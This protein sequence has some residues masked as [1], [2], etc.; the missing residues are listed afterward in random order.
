MQ[1]ME[2]LYGALA[3]QMISAAAELGIA[4]LLAG[5]PKAVAELAS[6]SG[7]DPEGL[8]RLLRGLAALG[9]FTETAPRTF[10]STP[11]GD[12]LRTDAEGSMRF[13]AQD[14]GGRTRL[15]AYSELAHSVR[16]GK[17]A[18]DKAHGTSMWSYLQSHPTELALF[19]KA[20]GNLASAAHSAAFQSYD[21]SGVRRL[22]DVGGGEGYLI[23]ALL[24]YY[25]DMTGV[26]FDEPHVVQGA[27]AV[28]AAAGLSDRT[29][30]AGGDAF[31][32]VPADGDVYVLSSILFSYLDDEVITLLSNIRKVM[33]PAGKILIL[34]PILP[35][36]NAY[37]PGKLLDV[38]QLALHRGGVRSEAEFTALF[39]AAGLRLGEIRRMWPAAPTDVV[40]AVAAEGAQ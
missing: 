33:N 26:L 17:P 34:E 5:G 20:M 35:E 30:I 37:H 11:L 22:V 10:A 36:G 13:L 27:S 21:L 16:T 12:T 6:A 29:E 9:V 18:F 38:T 4:D 7:A 15:L 31:A 8:Y 32:A 14:V 39:A 24:P 1:M 25:P 23:A 2:M 28:F 40:V 19:G 3:T